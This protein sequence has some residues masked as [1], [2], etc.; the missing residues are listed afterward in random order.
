MT[1]VVSDSCPNPYDC[2]VTFVSILIVSRVVILLVTLFLIPAVAA[3]FLGI[4]IHLP[5]PLHM[6]VNVGSIHQICLI[7]LVPIIVVH[8]L[9]VHAGKEDPVLCLREICVHYVNDVTVM[10]H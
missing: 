2:L 1:T 5:V 3:V 6:I 7:E 8:E 10:I 9:V 4:F